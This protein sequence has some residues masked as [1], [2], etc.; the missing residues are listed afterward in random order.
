[1]PLLP[2]V[3]G[4]DKRNRNFFRH[5]SGLRYGTFFSSH[6]GIFVRSGGTDAG[7]FHVANEGIPSIVIGVPARYIH[8][9]NAIMDIEDQVN[10]VKLVNAMVK[11]LDAATVEGF[12]KYI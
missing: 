5:I 11:R 8:S 9:H 12:V 2:V 1:M 7:S 10:A 6:T 4:S 3:T